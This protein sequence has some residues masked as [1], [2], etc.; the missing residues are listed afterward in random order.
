M[1]LDT[2]GIKGH[3]ALW[4]IGGDN[5]TSTHVNDGKVTDATGVNAPS[6]NTSLNST[7][8]HRPATIYEGDSDPDDWPSPI[9]LGHTDDIVWSTSTQD[10]QGKQR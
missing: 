4:I 5:D 7:A 8:T 9:S 6:V 2:G 3:R 10:G 1:G